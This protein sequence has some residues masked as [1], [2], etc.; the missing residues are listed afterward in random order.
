MDE[1]RSSRS[2]GSRG[3]FAKI[4][5][6]DGQLWCPRRGRVDIVEFFMCPLSGGLSPE[7]AER[8]LCGW[9]AFV[10]D[11]PAQLAARPV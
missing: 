11:G 10:P 5:V 1:I 6:V 4:P 9:S 8:V 2:H 7:H 3:Q